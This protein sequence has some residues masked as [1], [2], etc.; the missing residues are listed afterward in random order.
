M[1]RSHM[2]RP[3]LLIVDDEESVT[4]TLQLVFEDLGYAVDTALNSTEAITALANGHSYDAV[5]TDLN[6]EREDIGLEVARVA[7]QVRP[8][9]VVVICTGYASQTNA[10][11]ALEMHVDYFANKPVD[12]EEL[13]SNLDR[14]LARRGEIQSGRRKR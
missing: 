7:K 14:L 6:M 3:R 12:L 9:P 2:K 4:R 8:V 11:S 13:I 10:R 1:L 5:I